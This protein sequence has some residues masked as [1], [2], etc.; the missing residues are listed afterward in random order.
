MNPRIQLIA[1]LGSIA[2]AMFVFELI[3]RRKLRE[4][5]AL[6]WLG[7]SVVLLG[8]SFWR[9]S[10]DLAARIVGVAYPPSF[11]LL[12]VVVVGF[13]LAMHY[14]I[15]LSRLAEQN[16]RLAQELALLRYDVAKHNDW[17]HPSG[18]MAGDESSPA[19]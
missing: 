7:A 1:I 8:F 16:K 9:H 18:H 14:S 2:V 15:S 10:I 12:V 4:E 17:Q 6:F 19:A 5:Y 11:L 13:L 3:R